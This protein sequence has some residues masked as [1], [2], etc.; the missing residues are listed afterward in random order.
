M[1]H[2]GYQIE[3]P[4]FDIHDFAAGFDTVAKTILPKSPTQT[5][6]SNS[7]FDFSSS[8]YDLILCFYQHASN[9]QDYWQPILLAEI[10][11][12]IS[13]LICQAFNEELGTL[14]VFCREANKC[15]EDFVYL[16]RPIPTSLIHEVAIFGIISQWIPRWSTTHFAPLLRLL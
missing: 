9:P 7:S 5:Q 12:F 6:H 16:G 8:L 14:N 3:R 1:V 11:L 15:L 10:S 13:F 2:V 4:P